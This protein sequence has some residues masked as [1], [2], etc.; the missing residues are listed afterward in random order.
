ML[1]LLAKRAKGA[2]F[3]SL[4]GR[5]HTDMTEATRVTA[6]QDEDTD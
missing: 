4:Y 3:A 6:T 2:S 5:E 1:V